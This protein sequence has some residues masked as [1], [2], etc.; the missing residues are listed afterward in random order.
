MTKKELLKE[1]IVNFQKSSFKNITKR[2]IEL[3]LNI[4]KVVTLIGVRRSGKTFILF[5]T[6]NKLIS[7][8]TDKQDILYINF[9][10]ERLN[11][12]TEDL[13][14]IIQAWHELYPGRSSENLYLF[15]DEIQNVESWEKFIR[16]I[17][18]TITKNIFITGSNSS[19][20]SVDIATSLRGRSIQYEVF[21]FSFR[22]YLRH[23]NIEPDYYDSKNKAL[24][25][26]NFEQYLKYGGFPETIGVEEQ[27]HSDI[28]RNY[29]YVMLY[30]DLIERYKIPSISVLKIFIEKLADNLT[31]SFS[32]NKI[33]NDLR[34]QGFKL[35][36]NLL[37]ELIVYVENIYLAFK[38]S[39]FNRSFA[40]RSKADKKVYFIDNGIVNVL[41]MSL[42][43]NYGKMLE[44]SVFLFLRRKFGD[45]F[46][47][48]IFYHKNSKEC[49]FV[50]FDKKK[51]IAAIQVSYTIE[52]TET[53]KRETAGLINAMNDYGLNTGYIITNDNENEILKNGKLIKI[54]PAY[55]IMTNDSLDFQS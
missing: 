36:K 28:L 29:F 37:Y 3:P 5:D 45:L 10:D 26:S 9:E 55:K 25:I 48:N 22:E 27:L 30:K 11:F 42:S 17:Y 40:T 50:V 52:D 19:F 18:D 31:K 24:L 15:F 53:L 14:L 49:D 51:V 7:Q 12:K 16:R 32:I 6:I 46:N 20:L 54:V 35:D 13:D 41:T 8:G 23:L 34:S 33:Y 4:K 1:I 44:N 2:D 47:E 43:S 21:P 38:I 39:K